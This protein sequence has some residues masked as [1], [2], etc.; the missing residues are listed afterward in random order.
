MVLA[1]VTAIK[2]FDG[3]SIV[4]SKRSFVLH[5]HH[6]RGGKFAVPDCDGVVVL[7]GAGAVLLAVEWIICGCHLACHVLASSTRD[8]DCEKEYQSLSILS[9]EKSATKRMIVD[10]GEVL[11]TS[12]TKIVNQDEC[13]MDD[14]IHYTG[15]GMDRLKTY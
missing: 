6:A 8:S 14:W 4:I 9:R 13:V 2:R 11:A 12:T 1:L 15:C 3:M 7:I 5:R 10:E